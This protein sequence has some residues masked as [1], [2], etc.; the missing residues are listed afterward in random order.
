M[1]Q[2]FA[3][4]YALNASRGPTPGQKEEINQ[5]LEKKKQA[6]LIDKNLLNIEK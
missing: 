4:V 6:N 1:F 3:G 5:D 2:S